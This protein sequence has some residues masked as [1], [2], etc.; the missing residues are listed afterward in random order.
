M[1]D[2]KAMVKRNPQE[3]IRQAQAKW[4]KDLVG[5]QAKDFVEV[6]LA[7][8]FDPLLGELMPFQGRPYITLDARL[9]RAQRHPAWGGWAELRPATKEEKRE[10]GYA[11]EDVV[12][13]VQVIRKETQQP[14]V[15]G[16]VSQEELGKANAFTPLAK[17]SY[18]MAE[19]RAMHK[20]LRQGFADTI[21]LPAL[22]G[23]EEGG[24]DYV[25]RI[26]GEIVD[27]E[28]ELFPEDIPGPAPQPHQEGQQGASGPKAGAGVGETGPKPASVLAPHDFNAFWLAVSRLPGKKLTPPQVFEVLGV[29][30]LASWEAEG[31]TLD[32]ALE[33][34]KEKGG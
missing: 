33:K 14:L 17:D 29:V 9:R 27:G 8:G 31:K 12:A 5:Q 21:G 10:R 2:T 16:R 23:L 1:Q 28:A 4:P 13:A 32:E 25:D 3:L 15:F 30:G 22:P 11:T 26:T 7:Y 34:L 20:A 18:A 19:K 6:C 24:P